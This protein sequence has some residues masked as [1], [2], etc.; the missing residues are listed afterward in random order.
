M[1]AERNLHTFHEF[2]GNACRGLAVG[3]ATGYGLALMVDL[4]TGCGPSASA[5]SARPI[6]APEERPTQGMPSISG[7][8]GLAAVVVK[9]DG[10]LG[11]KKG[12]QV[13]V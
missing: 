13:V 2:P 8:S 11:T 1:E 12:V 7:M 4:G 3:S 10:E 6:Q 9:P 5:F